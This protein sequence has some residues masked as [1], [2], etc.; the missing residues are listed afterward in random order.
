MNQQ[1]LLPVPKPTLKPPRLIVG[2]GST[3]KPGVDLCPTCACACAGA[4]CKTPVSW[5]AGRIEVR[6]GRDD[7]RGGPVQV[8]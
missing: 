2:Y 5:S 4:G 7:D 8:D 6:E 3:D 1:E